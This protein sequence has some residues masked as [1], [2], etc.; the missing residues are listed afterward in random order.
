MRLIYF[1]MRFPVLSQ[2]FIQREVAGLRGHGIDLAVH[3]CL[4]SDAESR[5]VASVRNGVVEPGVALW[6]GG[7]LAVCGWTLRKPTVVLRMMG[8]IMAAP[9]RTAEQWFHSWLGMV[10]GARAAWDETEA[11]GFHGCWATAPAT[12]A[13]V[14]GRLTG[15]PFGFGAHAYDV[16]RHGGDPL[17]GVKLREAAWVHTT[18]EAARAELLRREPE[19]ASRLVLARRGLVQ[20]PPWRA[21][22]PIEGRELRVASVGRLVAKKGFRHQIAA[23]AELRR[24]GVPVRWRVIGEGPLRRSLE[25]EAAQQGVA[26]VMAWEGAQPEVEVWALH[27]WA[28]VLV[29]SGEVDAEGDRDGLPN[30]IPEAMASGVPVVTSAT[31]GPLE[32]VRDGVTGRVVDRLEGVWLAD[33]LEELAGDHDQRRMLARS[34]RAWVEENYSAAKNCGRLAE[35]MRRGRACGGVKTA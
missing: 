34:A 6:W 32:A 24:R 29:H 22:E 13:W 27:R 4:P 9:H 21:P 16:F 5:A 12:A 1:A 18:T 11:E 7:V 19:C 20:F 23:C 8:E 35:A 17:L 26:E 15:K 28:D 31:P 14:A 2:T 33:V 3:P 25:R 10:I 30:V